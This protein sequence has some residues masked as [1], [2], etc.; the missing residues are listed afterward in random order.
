ML[1]IPNPITQTMTT[2]VSHLR[3]ILQAHT[4][5]GLCTHPI[6]FCGH[7]WKVI[8]GRHPVTHTGLCISSQEKVTSRSCYGSLLSNRSNHKKEYYLAAQLT[9]TKGYIM[10]VFESLR[11]CCV[12]IRRSGTHT[13]H[14]VCMHMTIKAAGKFLAHRCI[15]PTAWQVVK[16]WSKWR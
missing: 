12:T 7:H 4:Q 15:R 8:S 14:R 2:F 13:H 1:L 11:G 5:A 3:I 16:E 6:W 9:H 10:E